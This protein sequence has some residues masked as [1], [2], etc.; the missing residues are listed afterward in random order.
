MQI[1]VCLKWHSFEFGR[2]DAVGLFEILEPVIA[3]FHKN[4]EK[5][6]CSFYGLFEDNLL[7]NKFRGG[8]TLTSNKLLAEEIGNH[9]LSFLA[10]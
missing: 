3:K 5:F 7:P 10:S 1:Y 2:Q 9:L 8:I 4:E 6:Y